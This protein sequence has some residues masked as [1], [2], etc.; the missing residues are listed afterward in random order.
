MMVNNMKSSMVG[1]KKSP[2]KLKVKHT[3]ET[4]KPLEQEAPPRK[5][6]IREW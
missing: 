6:I 3:L 1:A 5:P 4:T 2:T